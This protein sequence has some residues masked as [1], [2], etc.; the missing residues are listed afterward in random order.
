MPEISQRYDVTLTTLSPLHIGSGQ[1]LLRDYDYAV[2]AGRTWRINED[3]LLDAALGQESPDQKSAEWDAALLSQPAVNLLLEEDFKPDSSLFRYVARGVPRS[4]DKGAQLREQIKDVWDRLYLPGS[5][6]KGAL[7]TLLAEI[8]LT[9]EK[10][11]VRVNYRE[12]RRGRYQVKR[13]GNLLE[14]DAF[15]PAATEDRRADNPNHDLMRALQVADS[16]P[17]EAADG[18]AVVNAQVITRRG[19]GSPVEVEAVGPGIAFNTTILLDKYLFG[20]RAE[21]RLQF[22]SRRFQILQQLPGLART[23]V[24]QTIAAEADAYG[25]LNA[26]QVRGFYGGLVKLLTEELQGDEFLIRVGWGTGWGDKTLGERLTP[27]ELFTARQR[28]NLGRPPGARDW[29]PRRDEVFPASRRV[30]MRGGQP[31]LPFGWLRVKMTAQA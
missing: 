7:R 24:G 27:D 11:P 16:A 9:I 25:R 2:H 1:E 4:E 13:A 21:Q 8:I 10:Q 15:R 23:V 5:S 20:S 28:F 6:L 14:Q 29:R 17:V 22:G 26:P 3:A 18:L 30:A 12:D 31:W 19:Y